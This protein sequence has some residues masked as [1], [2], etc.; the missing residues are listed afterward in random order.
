MTLGLALNNALSGLVIN[1][2]AI[3]VLSNNIAN[4]NT[5]G[6]SKQYVNQSARVVNGLGSGV[7]LDDISRKIDKYLQRSVQTQASSYNGAQSLDDYYQ[8]L[9]AVLG[10]PGSANSVDVYMTSFFNQF[11]QLAESPEITSIKSNAIGSADTLAK[12]ISSLAAN[13]YDLRYESDRDI[14]DAVNEINASLDRLHN[15]NSSIRQ[16][17]ALKQ[18]SASLL[19]Q[20]DSELN[21]L[22]Q[23]MNITTSFDQSGAVSVVGG[24]G[25]TLVEEGVRHQITYTRSQSVGALV[26]NTAF[27]PLRV[28]T[29]NDQGQIIGS[30]RELI[31]GG[32]SSAVVSKVSGGKLYALQQVRDKKFPALLDQMDMLS[33]R[34]RDSVNELHNKGSGYPPATSLTGERKV[35]ATDQYSWSGQVRIAVLGP[36]G[37]PVTSPYADEQKSGGVRPLTMDLSGLDSGQGKGKPTLQTIIDEINNHFGAPGNKAE[38]GNINNIQLASDSSKLPSGAP[39]LFNFDLDLENI[40]Q[41]SASV[42]VTG[43]TV[44]DDASTNITNVTQTAPSLA[45]DP[46]NTYQ[47]T[48]GS[49]DVTISFTSNPGVQ[50]GQTIYMG[51]PGAPTVNGIPAA[52]LTGFFTVKSVSGNTVTFTSGA[53]AT[54][55]GTVA[56]ASGVTMMPPYDNVAAGQQQRTREQGQL[57]VDLSS[58]SSS[59]Y[60]DIT[61]DVS[62]VGSD[63]VVHTAP[64]TYRVDNNVNGVLNKRYDTTAVGGAG[65]LVL[66]TSSQETLRAIMVDADGN[67][68]PK[69]NGK[70]VDTDGYLKLVGSNN[71]D[72]YGV[73]I[74]EMDS[75]Q[76]GKPDGSPAEAGTNW[77]FSHYFGLNNFFASNGGG[78]PTGEQLL[79]SAY[80][81]KVGDRLL[82]NA[83]LISTGILSQVPPD[84]SNGNNTVY[85]YAR[86]SGDN[87]A[88][89]SLSQ[90]STTNVSF[91]Y[92]GGLPPTQQSL[93][94]YTGDMLGSMSQQS[95]QATDDLTSAK[96]LYDGFK[97]KSNSISGVNLD[98]ELANTIV[99]QNAYSATA[100]VISVVNQMYDDMLKA[101]G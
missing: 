59:R 82:T 92:A 22:S 88:I 58:G 43:M 54:A 41:G 76:L 81:L 11:Q 44:L 17:V 87:S 91:D 50:V 100:R 99:Y 94:G 31:S 40:S 48:L 1:Q 95:A 72:Q 80:N 51:A 12:Q 21:K 78:A 68:L 32:T 27:G 45:L 23:Y 85:T 83:N 42:F 79:N 33:S 69:S 77:G 61:L 89:Q 24:D 56:D 30:S 20:R 9:Q 36:N 64:I 10:Q 25:I 47:T 28:D 37:K 46:A 93:Q 15:I 84:T 2:Q 74:D 97:S 7:H 6:Y 65:T 90:L 53:S 63:G 60:F 49:P 96:V 18:S 66:P 39:P 55:T 67:E 3:G 71:G 35:R 26:Q 73:A 38:L 13:V 98:E 62:V 34:L 19:D 86:Y 101:F 70:Y 57:Q 4:V 5:E 75:A 16:G 8:R 29:L 14:S 52:S